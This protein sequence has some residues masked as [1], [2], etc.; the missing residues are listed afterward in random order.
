MF[1]FVLAVQLRAVMNSFLSSPEHFPFTSLT[2]NLVFCALEEDL[3]EMSRTW[4]KSIMLFTAH[5]VTYTRP[6]SPLDA[7]VAPLWLH[8]LVLS[9]G[10]P[11]LEHRLFYYLLGAHYT[12]WTFR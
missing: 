8:I 6:R 7:T 3:A 1:C 5:W 10:S 11:T 2:F 4:K 12:F 9:E